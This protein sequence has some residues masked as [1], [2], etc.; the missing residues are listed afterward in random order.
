MNP[1]VTQVLEVIV[2]NRERFEAFCMSLT[3]EE[4][5]RPVPGSTWVVKDF[6]SHLA[7]LDTFFTRHTSSLAD[8]GQ[9]DMTRDADGT[10]FDLDAWNDGQVAER[11]AW[12]MRRIFDGAATNRAALIEV[13][14]SLSD[15]ALDR[16]M[17]FSDP[18]RGTGDFPL[19]LF[20]VGWAQHDPIH[21]A[22]MLKALPTQAEDPEIKAWIANPFVSGY[23]KAMSV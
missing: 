23:Q 15:E 19:K 7:T 10:A 3:E 1:T 4:Q 22:D 17:H 12:T 8:G 5:M 16:T 14:R 2:A 20:L 13:L 9:I 21:A 6:A 18:K 11:R